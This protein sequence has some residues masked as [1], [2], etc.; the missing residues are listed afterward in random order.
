MSFSRK[1][2]SKNPFPSQIKRVAIVTPASTPEKE[3]IDRTRE[4]LQ[5]FGI[6]TVIAPHLFLETPVKGLPGSIEIRVAE[7]QNFWLDK[8]ID[9][10]LSSRGGYGSAELL[11][12]LEWKKLARRNI[13]VLGYSDITAL[14]LAMLKHGAGIP[15]T[16]PMA[17]DFLKVFECEYC[18]ASLFKVLETAFFQNPHKVDNFLD[19]IPFRLQRKL[20]VIKSGKT[21]GRLIPSNLTVFTSMIGTPHMPDMKGCIAVFEDIGEPLYKLDRCLTQIKQA[22]LM[23]EFAGIVFADFKNCGNSVDR[24]QLFA[25]FADYVNGPVLSG[26]PFGH[27]SPTLSFA[28]GEKVFIA[29]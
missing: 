20:R 4:L 15:I 21:D 26:V 6:E 22:G 13:P 5:G 19:R 1:K 24:N 10:I 16:S 11:D 28:V 12:Y 14:H 29:I 25:K 8:S 7:L 27:T 2:Q 23:G 3:K 17:E 18:S 9:L